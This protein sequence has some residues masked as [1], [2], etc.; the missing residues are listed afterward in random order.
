MAVVGVKFNNKGKKYLFDSKD[1]ILKENITVIVET[2]KGLQFGTVVSCN[3]K[4]EKK[5]LKSVIRKSTKKDY[6]QHLNNLKDAKEAIKK[7]RE[8]AEKLKLDMVIMDSMYTFDRTQLIFRFIADE[9]IDFRQLAKELGTIFKTRIELRQV[10]IRDKA[11]EIGGY[12]PCGRKM[13]CAAFLNEFDSV[14]INMAKN[15]NLA[16]NPSKINGT[17]GRLMCCLKYEDDNYHEYKKNLPTLG[18]KIKTEDYEGRVVAV[19]IFNK[20][21]KVLTDNN[22]II[23]VELE[24]NG[25]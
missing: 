15:Q 18:K 2:D 8:L 12:G 17:C 13:C 11:K 22:N 24:K 14:S 6:L 20:T 10:G 7:A 3:E 9:R 21:Y 1:L 19:D 4:T 23:E 25:S 16:L 5:D